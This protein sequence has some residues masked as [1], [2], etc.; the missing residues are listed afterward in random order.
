MLFKKKKKN[1]FGLFSA[2]LDGYRKER[3]RQAAEARRS[4]SNPGQLLSAMRHMV[5]C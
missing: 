1:F 3:G 2:F 5:A 4:D